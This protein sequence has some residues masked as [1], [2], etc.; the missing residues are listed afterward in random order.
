M[1]RS[2][3]DQVEDFVFGD[4]VKLLRFLNHKKTEKSEILSVVSLLLPRIQT[5]G[6]LEKVE[7][8]LYTSVYYFMLQG[9]PIREC[10][11][12]TLFF[13]FLLKHKS[14]EKI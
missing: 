3:R 11:F 13:V 14:A 10:K 12:I 8:M 1:Q 5:D 9:G 2:N 7:D 6:V 4:P